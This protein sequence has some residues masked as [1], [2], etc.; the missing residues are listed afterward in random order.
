MLCHSINE[1]RLDLKVLYS[2]SSLY[3]LFVNFSL[4]AVWN[5]ITGT[6]VC[7]AWSYLQ[8]TNLG[9]KALDG[10]WAELESLEIR[11]IWELA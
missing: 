8:R 7:M 3:F 1:T 2:D 10:S 5:I 11:E 9:K 6:A 4:L